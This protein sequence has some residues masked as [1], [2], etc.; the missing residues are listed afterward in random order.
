MTKNG[1]E[2]GPERCARIVALI[3]ERLD[4]YGRWARAAG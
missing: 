2:R 1:K 3:D 4:D